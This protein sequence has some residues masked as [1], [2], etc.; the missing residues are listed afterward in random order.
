M[1]SSEPD[2]PV[3]AADTPAI[4]AIPTAP[5]APGPA[6][7]PPVPAFPEP[8]VEPVTTSSGF[9]NPHGLP[10][11]AVERPEVGVGGAFAGGL[12]LALILKR[13]AR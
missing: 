1:T 4:P 5:V 12:V 6:D 11:I 2:V 10:E 9:P 8:P 7:L 3:P 13:L